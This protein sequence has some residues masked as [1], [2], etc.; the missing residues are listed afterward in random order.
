M[1]KQQEHAH[2]K[3][4]LAGQKQH[5]SDTTDNHITRPL[6]PSELCET[7]QNV[8]QGIMPSSS[9]GKDVCNVYMTFD[10]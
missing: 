2:S 3:M 5:P 6:N 7:A 10:V 9:Y 8:L 4:C 1:N